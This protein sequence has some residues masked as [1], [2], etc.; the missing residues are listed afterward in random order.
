MPNNNHKRHIRARMAITGES[1]GTARL[2]Y[3][4]ERGLPA[5][6]PTSATT[7]RRR[8]Q[9]VIAEYG[10]HLG[11]PLPVKP[12]RWAT[13]KGTEPRVALVDTNAPPLVVEQVV[14]GRAR[15]R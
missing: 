10:E 8:E 14:A 3:L 5:D 2:A 7:A 1:Y 6:T 12:E 13:V 4:A 15:P 11:V 9:R